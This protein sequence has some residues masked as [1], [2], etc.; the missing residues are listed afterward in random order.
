MAIPKCENI[1]VMSFNSQPLRQRGPPN[2]AGGIDV[3]IP[4]GYGPGIDGGMS[5]AERF[6]DEKRRICQSCFNKTDT[7]G[8]GELLSLSSGRGETSCESNVQHLTAFG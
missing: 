6:E 2:G 4:S 5:R 7:D 3:R 8:Q 1:T